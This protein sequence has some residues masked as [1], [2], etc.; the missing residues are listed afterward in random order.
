VHRSFIGDLFGSFADTAILLPLIT[1]LS[2]QAGFNPAIL[3]FG[4]GIAY[5]LAGYVFKIPM[6]VQPL[7]SIAIAAVSI[8]A[9]LTEIQISGF[10]LGLFCLSLLY[11]DV[12]RISK[13]IPT[14]LIQNIQFGLGILLIEQALPKSIN[15]SNQMWIG[16]SLIAVFLIL[17]KLIRFSWLGIFTTVMT[18]SA[19][20]SDNSSS[21]LL[22]SPDTRWSIVLGLVLPQMVLTIGNSILGTVLAAKKYFPEKS[23]RVTPRNLLLSVGIGNIITALITGLPFCHGSGGIT[24]HVKGGATSSRSNYIMGTFLLVLSLFILISGN[25]ITFS[26]PAFALTALLGTVGFHHL[27]LAKDLFSSRSRIIQLVITALLVLSTHNLLFVFAWALMF[28]FVFRKQFSI[29][30]Q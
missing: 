18:L 5:L 10:L 24:A 23:E 4:C 30:K 13:N 16:L 17:G 3:F 20:S 11:F 26:Y 28:E 1:L 9:S 19:F 8:G 22:T 14:P 29:I 27:N 25:K 12:N 7:K 21:Q 15:G 2:T 6:S